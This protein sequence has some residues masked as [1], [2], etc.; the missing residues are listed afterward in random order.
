MQYQEALDYINNMPRLGTRLGVYRIVELL[1]LLGDPH[2]RLKF[3][4]VAGTNGKG[5]T[6][7]MAASIARAA[8]L[9]CGLY[10]S[11][12]VEDFCERI[13]INGEKIP[14]DVLLA[15]TEKIA[16]LVADMQSRGFDITHFEICMAI[17]VDYYAREGCDI[18]IFEV[19]LGG[20]F[21]ATNCIDPPEVCVIGSISF[22]HTELL[23]DTLAKIAG[24]KCGIIKKTSSAA[25][26]PCQPAEALEVIT[27][28]CAEHGI[29]PNIPSLS[30]LQITSCDETGSK[31][32]Y[33]NMPYEIALIGKHQIYNALSVIAIFEELNSRGWSFSQSDIV[34]GL[35]TADFGGRMEVVCKKPLCVIDGAHNPDG[36]D[37]LCQS[38]KTLYKNRKIT[39]VMGMLADKNYEYGVSQVAELA[40][41]FIAVTPDTPRGLDCEA[42]AE[43]ARKYC[44]DV[45]AIASP[46]NGARL[47]KSELQADEM[48][49]ACG[50]LYMIGDA[51][52]GLQD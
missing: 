15:Q 28:T 45:R 8:G 21:D 26:Y 41:K 27:A 22:D 14:R 37:S 5:S 6:C 47:A 42:A 48:L 46:Q 24:E 32:I 9:K 49:I 10:I 25:I 18:V 40:T 23:G 52:R 13:Q 30:D 50:S 51:K 44:A 2:K 20:K 36:I 16:L 33:K 35:S 29:S 17:A 11:P 3:V 31:F 4:H 7:A 39:I 19:G 43:I 34:H 1:R 12:Y 38:I